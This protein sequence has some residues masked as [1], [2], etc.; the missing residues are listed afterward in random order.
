MK[1]WLDVHNLTVPDGD[2]ANEC[3]MREQVQREL[4][5]LMTAGGSGGKVVDRSKSE[6]SSAGIA[7]S[8]FEAVSQARG[9]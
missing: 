2:M 6:S 3:Q 8:I 1:I 4:A 9:K 5:S 7:R